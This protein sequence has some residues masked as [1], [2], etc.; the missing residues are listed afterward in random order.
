MRFTEALFDGELFDDPA[1]LDAML[2]FDETFDPAYLPEELPNQR[3]GLAVIQMDA[4]GVRLEGHL[5]H[6]AGFNAAALR[7]PDSGALIVVTS[8]DDRAYAAFTVF[9]VA[10]LVRGL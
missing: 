7:D 3:V 1:T 6:F 2:R 5:G 4:D 8:N 9:D 10:K